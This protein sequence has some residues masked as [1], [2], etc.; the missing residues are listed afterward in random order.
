MENKLQLVKSD[1]FGEVQCDFYGNGKNDFFMTR[2]QIGESLEYSDPQVAIDKI[3]A[4]HKARLDKYSVTT[5]LVGTDGKAYDTIVYSRK[6]IMEICR[7]SQQP[8]ADA[9]MDWT[10]NIM[11]ALMT[12]NAKIVS[13]SDL[14]RIKIEAAKNRADAMALNAKTRAFKAIMNTFDGSKYSPIAAEVFGLT[15]VQQV[16]GQKIV[17]QPEFEKSWTATDIHDETGVCASTIGKIAKAAGLKSDKYGKAILNH[18]PGQAKQV[19]EFHYN[20]KGHDLVLTAVE[21]WK[22]NHMKKSK[23]RSKTTSQEDC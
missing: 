7:W 20:T 17:M 19:P 16:T 9:F 23:V 15:A 10:W 6:G 14:E 1:K 4:R 11:D 13:V 5:K 12:G 21:K 3:H 2:R 18:V 8:K 22:I